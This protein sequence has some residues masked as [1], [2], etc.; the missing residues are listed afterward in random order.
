MRGQAVP[1]AVQGGERLLRGL[2]QARAAICFFR[3]SSIAVIA[4]SQAACVF[5]S[6]PAAACFSCGA[7]TVLPAQ[8]AMSSVWAA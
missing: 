4:S 2:L 7:G 8:A 1:F 6:R 5:S 3:T